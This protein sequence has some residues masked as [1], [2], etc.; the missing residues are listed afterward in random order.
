MAA[1]CIERSKEWN[2][3]LKLYSSSLNVCPNNAKVHYNIAKV[4]ANRGDFGSAEEEYLHAISLNPTYE[5]ALNNLALLFEKRG[6]L[7]KS[8]AILKNSLKIK[9]DFATAWMNLGIVQ[10]KLDK[11]E[12]SENSFYEALRRRPKHADTLFNLG[13][14]YLKQNRLAEAKNCWHNATSL[15]PKHL[16]AWVNLF[17]LLEEQDECLA[18]EFLAP[19][20]FEHHPHSPV[21]H[22]QYGLC[23]ARLG[24]FEAAEESLKK[25]IE[26]DSKNAMFWGNLGTLYHRSVE[27]VK[28][29]KAYEKSLLLEPTNLVVKNNYEKLLED[30]RKSI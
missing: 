18:V 17:I 7:E 23:M 15:E 24:K 2:D 1:K 25:A 22:S 4:L 11:F 27:Y 21:L 13:N 28:S 9:P 29:R 20:A 10:L 6:L 26:L 16:E 30:I 19:L 3:E 8:E 5:Q 12:D 14:L